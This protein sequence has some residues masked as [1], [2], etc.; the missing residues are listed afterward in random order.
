MPV[1]N[2]RTE[3]RHAT[4]GNVCNHFAKYGM[5]CDSFDLLRARAGGRC[6]ICQTPEGQT[7][8][9]ALVID[10]FEGGGLYFVRGLLCDRCNSVMSRHDRHAEWGPS[11][12]PWAERARAYH[13]AAFEQP[14]AEEFAQAEEHIASRKPYSVKDRVLPKVKRPKAYYVRLDRPLPEIANK[15][16]HRLSAEQRAQLIELLSKPRLPT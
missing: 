3:T 13:L 5:T 12:L 7:T 16:R 2:R 11:S 10:H 8:R 6:E 14:S 9:G 15:L 4:P 1:P